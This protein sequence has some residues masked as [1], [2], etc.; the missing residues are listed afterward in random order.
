MIKIS[1]FKALRP[2][3]GK[4]GAIISPPY[5]V[6]DTETAREQAEGNPLSFLRVIRSEIE[7]PPDS[8]PYDKAVYERARDNLNRL[9]KNGDLIRE[10]NPALYIYRLERGGHTQTG[11]VA[12][13]HVE[14]Y[15]SEKIKKH[16]LTRR[17]KE[18]D[19]TRHVDTLGANTGLIFLTFR[20]SRAQQIAGALSAIVAESKPLYDVL[21]G[22][23]V[24]H[25]IYR[26]DDSK[27]IEEL[28]ELYRNV[29][30]LYIADGHHRA[31]SAARA[32]GLHR[33]RAGTF[34]GDE[35]FNWFLGVS[36][37]DEELRIYPYNRVVKDLNGHSAEDFLEKL[38]ENFEVV[39]EHAE[40]APRQMGLFLGGKW[41]TLKARDALYQAN[42][43]NEKLDVSILQKYVLQPLLGIDDPRT[44][45]R[46]A[47]IGGL[48]SEPV[49]EAK[50]KS[51]EYAL[52]FSLYPTTPQELEDIA[53][54]GEI[55][56]PKSTWFEPKLCSGFIINE[57]S[58][59]RI[60][61]G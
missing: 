26:I 45:E 32:A 10:E 50:V 15:L 37:P 43:A 38:E 44:S 61:N 22:D 17:D 14:D 36:F 13:H 51:G 25:I 57:I 9:Q 60:G 3:P 54:A 11:L 42:S 18:D 24:R 28:T 56:S 53:D 52:A 55:M 21:R 48:D 59:T 30:A 33:E 27:K 5:D 1:P 40:P 58:A 6:I 46:I 31:A 29:E 34:S 16:E 4:E 39:A 41:Y 12:R 19:R 20:A 49:L 8:N 2:A 35:D 7:F 23:G 47:F